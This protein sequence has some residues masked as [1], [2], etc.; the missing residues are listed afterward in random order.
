MCRD[1]FASSALAGWMRSPRPSSTA[2]TGCCAS[3]STSRSRCRR[4]N[5]SAIATSRR[6]WPS[7][8]GDEMKSARFRRDRPRA[9]WAVGAGGATKSRRSRFTFTG[10]RPCGACPDPSI[11][12]NVPPR[13]STSAAPDSGDRIPR[14]RSEAVTAA[15]DV[16]AARASRLARATPTTSV[17]SSATASGSSTRSTARGDFELDLVEPGVAC[18]LACGLDGTCV[19]V[20]AG[21]LRVRERVGHQ[22][23]RRPV[24]A[25]DVR[26]R[27]AALELLEDTVQRRQPGSAS[28]SPSTNSTFGTPSASFRAPARNPGE[29]STP[30]T[31]STAGSRASAR[32]TAPV[33]H[34]TSSIRAPLSSSRSAK[35]AFRI[36]CCCGSAAVSSRIRASP[37]MTSGSASAIVR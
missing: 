13:S 37:S 24:P 4:R 23:R 28:A 5:S 30:M 32:V 21:E 7:P 9:Q 27:D 14:L 10:S 36:A 31:D 3:Q 12:T 6:A 11:R 1:S 35:Y 16:I 33:P 15:V 2:V 26:D 34:P 25:P 29:G 17:T 22:D 8:I 20:R 18:P 19:V